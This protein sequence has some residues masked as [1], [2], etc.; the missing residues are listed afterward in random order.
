MSYQK[1]FVVSV[2]VLGYH[3]SNV[4]AKMGL[5]NAVFIVNWAFGFFIGVP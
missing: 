4:M 1:P 5:T 3:K 2:S